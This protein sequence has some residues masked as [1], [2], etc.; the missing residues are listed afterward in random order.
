MSSVVYVFLAN[1]KQGE[2][3]ALSAAVLLLSFHLHARISE[4]D[5]IKLGTNHTFMLDFFF[6]WA[7]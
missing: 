3:T 2:N 6:Y 4:L 1:P 5:L 7:K